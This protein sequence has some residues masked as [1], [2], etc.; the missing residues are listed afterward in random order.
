MG[1]QFVENVEESG[2]RVNFDDD[3]YQQS[4][5]EGTKPPQ[6]RD[7]MQAACA[8]LGDSGCPTD[9]TWTE[10]H[11][12]LHENEITSI[13]PDDQD[14]PQDKPLLNGHTSLIFF[15]IEEDF[16][17]P[18]WH[19]PVDD[20]DSSSNTNIGGTNVGGTNIGGGGPICTGSNRV[21][22][23]HIS[24]GDNGCRPVNCPFGR[25]A[26]G[27]CLAPDYTEPP[28]IYVRG[29]GNV[30]EDAGSASFQA[31][32]SHPVP[33]TVTVTVATQDGTATANS[34]YT[35][36]NRRVTFRP[37]HT[38]AH[39]SV[40]ITDD[41]RDE[42]DET[43]TLRLSNP[44]S[45]AT[46]NTTAAAE[47]TIA[48]D[49]G[50]QFLGSVTNLNAV[51]V[52]GQITVSW[53]PP[54]GSNS[55]NDYRYGIYRDPN[56]V[57]RVAGGIT[58]ETQ[59]TVDVTDTTLTYYAEVQA[60]GGQN[61]NRASWL[62]TGGFTCTVS[63]PVVSLADTSLSVGEN[64]SVQITATLDVVPS[65]TAS[66]RFYLPRATNGNGSCTA[67]A[68]FYVSDTEF[69]FTNTTSASITLIT[70]DD[71]DTADETVTL[72]LTATGITG[73]QLGSPTR[74]VVTI[75]D[76]DTA[77]TPVVSLTSTT[78]AVGEMQSIQ[79]TASLDMMPSNTASVRFALSG[80]TNG[81]GSCSA[82]G[83]DFYVS[84]TEFTFTN[85]TSA[86]VT[87]HACDDD[88]TADETVTL[89]LTTLGITELQLGVAHQSRGDHHRRRHGLGSASE[90]TR[91]EVG[92]PAGV[93]GRGD[94]R[95]AANVRV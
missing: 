76:D 35:P 75:T 95:V 63:A 40:P 8:G 39:V 23:V 91:R 72:A 82:A 31:V 43:F 15:R 93:G 27:W 44:S 48:D 80:A 69:T 60:R 52:S 22:A 53:G 57:Y 55:V 20:A 84:D 49:D 59:V 56:Y 11:K 65:S 71:T 12:W 54:A 21:I 90:M 79:V 45:N 5:D 24:A 2:K 7:G 58:T 28:V 38:V 92:H 51:C 33:R 83:A 42:P 85:A 4:L 10:Q 41:T 17:E 66:V 1:E 19:P 89:A 77:L 50:P 81:N 70:C 18:G 13:D 37:N 47:A 36:V 67:G 16:S 61:P 30:D 64:S 46:L 9:A 25:G 78:L 6:W 29:P 87:L 26:D 32:L 73:L 68:D 74:V 86:S 34:D 94:V 88:D 3:A 14:F 62:P